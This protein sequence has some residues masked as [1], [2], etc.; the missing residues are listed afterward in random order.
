MHIA[1]SLDDVF[2]VNGC[3]RHLKVGYFVEIVEKG[4]TIHVLHHEIDVVFLLE[5]SIKLHN[6]GMVEACVQ[7]N[8]LDKLIDHFVFDDCLLFYF[9]DRRYKT[10]GLMPG[11]EYL[12]KLAFT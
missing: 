8:L 5:N 11:Q 3:H 10:T 9:L 6:I 4:S 2:E 12:P 7:P 1:Q